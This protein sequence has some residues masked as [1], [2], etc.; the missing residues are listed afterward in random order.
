MQH[1]RSIL[2]RLLLR[3]QTAL[4]PT[5][6]WKLPPWTRSTS[7]GSAPI[8]CCCGDEQRSSFARLRGFVRAGRTDVRTVD[9]GRPEHRADAEAWLPSCA[10]SHVIFAHNQGLRGHETMFVERFLE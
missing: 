8:D 10:C 6:S 2:G 3:D 5:S 4:T 7:A 9:A 1:G